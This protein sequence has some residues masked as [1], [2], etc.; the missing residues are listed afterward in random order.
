MS[1]EFNSLFD[2]YIP[3][4]GLK[5]NIDLSIPIVIEERIINEK[6]LNVLRIQSYENYLKSSSKLINK[7]DIEPC[8]SI[9]SYSSQ[10]HNTMEV[11][12]V[13][14]LISALY[15]AK[16]ML[17]E[18]KIE[19]NY[20]RENMK[21]Y[22]SIEIARKYFMKEDNQF[23]KNYAIHGY[24]DEDGHIEDTYWY[25]TLG[26]KRLTK[27]DFDR[28][29]SRG[30]SNGLWDEYNRQINR[31]FPTIFLKI[32]DGF[33]NKLKMII[34]RVNDEDEYSKKIRS[35]LRL[36]YN[37]L[38][39]DDIEQSI[40]TYTTILE[41]LLL[42]KQ[43]S[44]GQKN[45]VANRA[46]CIV[47]YGAKREQK[48]FIAN[49]MSYFY[50]YRNKIVHEGKSFLELDDD[51]VI[52]NNFIKYVRHIIF[53]VFKY[54]VENN[55]TSISQIRELAVN[56]LIEDKIIK[57]KDEETNGY[58]TYSKDSNDKIPLIYQEEY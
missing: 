9:I 17:S 16:R 24:F 38:Y 33:I 45:K 36:Y 44:K 2:K 20:I 18:S 19:E 57:S 8:D 50:S 27:D 7:Y 53:Y 51:E 6:F 47:G 41:T 25:I 52:F 46:A 30:Y 5:I 42:R 34:D 54:I 43:E 37:V 32:D 48:N 1:D 4:N 40:L 12:N 58:I 39:E 23:F 26:N 28:S 3:V 13:K 55:I 11:M 49:V 31:K 22:K 10:R 15:F 21:W 14:I 35:A 29:L 56:E